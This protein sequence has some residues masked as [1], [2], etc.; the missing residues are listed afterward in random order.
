M[1][2]I[3][4]SRVETGTLSLKPLTGIQSSETNNR[5]AASN[6][7]KC[8]QR[9]WNAENTHCEADLDKDHSGTLPTNG[10]EFNTIDLCLEDLSG[11]SYL[12]V[13]DEIFSIRCFSNWSFLHLRESDV[14]LAG[15][16]GY[17]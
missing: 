1:I 14:L 2:S 16:G 5:K 7:S 3:V 4:S 15:R 13:G 17:R 10:P 6:G 8:C 9:S 12:C 11:F